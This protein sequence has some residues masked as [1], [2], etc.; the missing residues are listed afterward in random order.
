MRSSPKRERGPLRT[1]VGEAVGTDGLVYDKLECSH[2][3]LLSW[4][5]LRQLTRARR[6]CPLCVGME[7]PEAA[8]ARSITPR[9]LSA[10]RARA[11]LDASSR[12]R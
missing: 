11:S 7:T 4:S 9:A 5:T 2:R 8:A 12:D 1:I 3:L 10:R 6:A